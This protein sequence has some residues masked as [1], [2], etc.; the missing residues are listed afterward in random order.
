MSFKNE[1]I[2]GGIPHENTQTLVDNQGGAITS[3]HSQLHFMGQTTLESSLARDGG[4]ILAIS[5]ALWVYGTMFLAY[6]TAVNG[7][8][9]IYLEGSDLEIIGNC[10]NYLTK[11]SYK[12]RGDIG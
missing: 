11:P 7:G 1:V 5:G 8:G 2:M 6:N 10:N 4:A 3:F 9:G 12:R